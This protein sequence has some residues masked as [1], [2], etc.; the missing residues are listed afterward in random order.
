MS[1]EIL[2]YIPTTRFANQNGL[3]GNHFRFSIAALPDLTFFAQSITIPS[4]TTVTADRP[5]PFIKIHEVAD[6]LE[7]SPLQ[8]TYQLDAA[9]QTYRSLLWW[10]QGYGFPHSYDEVKEFREARAKQI[11]TPYPIARQLEKTEATL[12]ILQPD[13]DSIIAELNFVDVFPT[14]LGE[15]TFAVTDSDAP[16]LTTTVTFA[17]TTFDLK[18]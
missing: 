7:H 15:V 11:P 4:I 18:F 6:H 9:L 12:L 17:C 3:L 5:T 13:T 14:S 2:S 10:I 1:D 16:L 8:V